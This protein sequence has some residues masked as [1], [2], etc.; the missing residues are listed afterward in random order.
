M[1]LLATSIVLAWLSQS[2]LSN[3]EQRTVTLLQ[4]MNIFQNRTTLLRI[5][6]IVVSKDCTLPSIILQVLFYLNMVETEHCTFFREYIA[7]FKHPFNTDD[8]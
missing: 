7:N 5:G 2:G 3:K 8:M 4:W 6:F 1:I